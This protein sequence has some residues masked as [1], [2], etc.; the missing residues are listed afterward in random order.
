MLSLIS[1]LFARLFSNT[2]LFWT[3]LKT[4]F[5]TL[6][7][8]VLPIILTNVFKAIVDGV[9]SLITSMIGSVSPLA[10]SLTGLAGWLASALSVPACFAIL[11]T[12]IAIKF[13]LRLIPF[14]RI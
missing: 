4:V 8:T 9:L 2:E 11:F 1:A 7:I 6:T 3:A 14:V 10:V 13:T 12:A 5:S